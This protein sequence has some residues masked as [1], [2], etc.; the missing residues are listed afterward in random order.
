MMNKEDIIKRL[1]TTE[2]VPTLEEVDFIIEDNKKETEDISKEIL[3]KAKECRELGETNSHIPEAKKYFEF[4]EEYI[5]MEKGLWE[6]HYSAEREWIQ[7]RE[8][9]ESVLERTEGIEKYYRAVLKLLDEK[10]M[11]KH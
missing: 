3:A 9:L 8:D 10:R 2:D 6:E 7:V 11:T 5:A 1:V 4:E